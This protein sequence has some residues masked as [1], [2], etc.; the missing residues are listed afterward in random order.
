MTC[1]YAGRADSVDYY[2][3]TIVGIATGPV[4]AQIEYV[5]ATCDS[6]TRCYRGASESATTGWRWVVRVQVAAGYQ[7]SGQISDG[8]TLFAANASP[9]RK[10]LLA[11]YTKVCP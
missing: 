9:S 7:Y 11:N 10:T 6:W 5:N 1:T 4:G 2:D 8:V 3:A